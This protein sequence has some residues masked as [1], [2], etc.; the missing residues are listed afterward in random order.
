MI[1]FIPTIVF[2]LEA[3]TDVSKSCGPRKNDIGL[4]ARGE[5]SS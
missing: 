3:G 1:C 5:S 2:G 4:K